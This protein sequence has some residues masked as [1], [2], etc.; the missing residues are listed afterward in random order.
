MLRRTRL[1]QATATLFAPERLYLVAL[2]CSGLAAVGSVALPATE[3]GQLAATIVSATLGASIGGLSIDTFLLSRPE[4]WV[5]FRGQRW[6]LGLLLGSLLGSA[7]VAAIVSAIT[8]FADAP[9]AMAGAVVLTVFNA[10]SALDLRVKRFLLVYVVRAVAG[11][12]L[13][14]GYAALYL[15][16]DRSGRHWS[17]VW[18]VAQAAAAVAMAVEVFA[19]AQRFNTNSTPPPVRVADRRS[20]ARALANLHLGICAQMLTFRLDQV[21]LARFAGSGPLGVYALAVS[22]IEF[23]QAGSVVTAQKILADRSSTRDIARMS[24][25]VKATLP[26]AVLAVG[27][28]FGLGLVVGQY[29]DAWY[30]GLVLVPGCVAVAIGKAWSANLLKLRGENATT[31]VAL[32]T[33]AV[34]VPCYLALIPTIGAVGAAIASSFVYAVSAAGSRLSLRRRPKPHLSSAGA[35]QWMSRSSS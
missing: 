4:G 22:A 30:L 29:R 17:G 33:V 13:I 7:G 20:D 3:R 19:K 35:S 15:H 28:L 25:L 23:A 2:A 34:A 6:I 21:L 24:P 10:L 18:L 27:G 26:I 1:G 32:V 14:G 31:V 11:V 5:A 9:V 16:G 8:G 12:L